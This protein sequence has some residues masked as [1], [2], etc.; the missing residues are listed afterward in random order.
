MNKKGQ[1]GQML[2]IYTFFII[3]AII[4][5]LGV[6]IVLGSATVNYVG[7]NILPPIQTQTTDLAGDTAGGAVGVLVTANNAIPWIVGVIYI[8]ALVFILI[9]AYAF[10]ISGE[11]YLL[12]LYL[13]LSVLIVL[14]AILTSNLYQDFYKAP[15]DLGDELKSMGLI[16][17]LILYS[18]MIMSFILG[19][20]AIIIFSGIKE[21]NLL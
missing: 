3:V 5:G 14:M 11:K 20:A 19:F 10:R 21:E 6:F 8:L 9:L 13:G 7:D 1:I 15:G 18:P 4:I 17:Y 2:N 12:V 16:S